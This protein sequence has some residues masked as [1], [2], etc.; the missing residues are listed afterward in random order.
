MAGVL[1]AEHRVGDET[2]VGRRRRDRLGVDLR[3]LVD[4]LVA[5]HHL[6]ERAGT[7]GAPCRARRG[8]GRSRPA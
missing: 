4:P 2:E 6:G 7:R 3:R 5:E 1:Q 8:R